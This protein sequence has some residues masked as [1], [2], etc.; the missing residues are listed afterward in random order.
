VARDWRD[1][2]IEE[3]ERENAQLRARIDEQQ[4]L[5]ATLERRI[6]ELEVKLARFSGNSS[7]PPSSDPPG[8]PPPAPPKRKGRKRGGQPGH[9]RHTRTL[10]PLE[11]V[12]RTQVV[13]PC[14]CRHRG[15]ALHGEDADPYRHQVIDIPKVVATVEE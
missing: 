4:A 8:A 11:K 12:T 3:L 1:E 13:K 5:I 7:K 6:Q 2:R 9:E 10:V 15:S 14:A